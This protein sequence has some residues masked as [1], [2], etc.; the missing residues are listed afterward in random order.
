MLFLIILL[1]LNLSFLSLSTNK[2]A[3]I[4]E[5]FCSKSVCPIAS[6]YSTH[7]FATSFDV[8][9]YHTDDV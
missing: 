3:Y 1:T 8:H 2:T 7:H 5:K 4:A 9:M 6:S